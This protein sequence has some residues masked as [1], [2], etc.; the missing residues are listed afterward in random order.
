MAQIRPY[1]SE[2]FNILESSSYFHSK[3]FRLPDVLL[4]LTN[5]NIN[6]IQPPPLAYV[7]MKNL[8]KPF[9][10]LLFVK[11]LLYLRIMLGGSYYSGLSFSN[12]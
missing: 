7:N 9:G 5:I 4:N 3:Y 11:Y 10:K 12:D 8:D 2:D 1:L 6:E